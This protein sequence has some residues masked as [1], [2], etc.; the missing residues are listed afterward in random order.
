[1]YLKLATLLTLLALSMPALTQGRSARLA[2]SRRPDWIPHL[3]GVLHVDRSPNM[4]LIRPGKFICI[5]ITSSPTKDFT[6]KGEITLPLP[7]IAAGFTFYAQAAMHDLTQST[8]WA[9]TNGL[10]VVSGRS[11]LGDGMQHIP[12]HVLRAD[13]HFQAVTGNWVG[14]TAASLQVEAHADQLR[15]RRDGER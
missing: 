1:M 3:G 12:Q 14:A 6:G 9:L 2:L 4:L 7:A 11:G 13:H 10:K 5:P 8:R 15:I